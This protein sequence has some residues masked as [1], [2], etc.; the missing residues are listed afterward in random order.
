MVHRIAAL[1]ESAGN[2]HA[3]GMC[4]RQGVV[5]ASGIVIGEDERYAQ[6]VLADRRQ[7][8][9]RR[10]TPRTNLDVTGPALQAGQIHRLLPLQRHFQHV[11][12]YIFEH[13][14]HGDGGLQQ[15]GA[16]R[17]GIGA[18]VVIGAAVARRF[19][20]PSGEG[21]EHVAL[22]R[23]AGRPAQ[24]P[25]GFA[26]AKG[27][28]SFRQFQ[29]IAAGIDGE[30]SRARTVRQLAHHPVEPDR[31]VPQRFV[32]HGGVLD[33]NQEIALAFAGSAM[34]GIINKAGGLRPAG[35]HRVDIGTERRHHLGPAGIL[36]HIAR[37][38]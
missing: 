22:F 11:E 8:R 21:N 36:H 30:D 35:L 29:Y 28:F 37:N 25:E 15:P 3:V 18:V 4:V 13:V 33:R 19:A 32:Q 10:T 16:E 20:L 9:S 27:A 26:A 2:F 5:S 23:A 38:Q 1:A 12:A 34:A 17:L 6:R 7:G 31:I 24:A 14:T